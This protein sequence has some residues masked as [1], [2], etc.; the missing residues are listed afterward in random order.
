MLSDENAMR[1]VRGEDI[2]MVFQEPMTSLNPLHTI[3]RQ[4]GEILK[5]HRGMS[6]RDARART[7]ELLAL[8]GIRDAESRLGAYPHQLSGRAA[9]ARDDRHVLSPTSPIFSSPTS[10]PRPSTS[11]YR[12][13]S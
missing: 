13:R 3:E 12:R 1:R 2:T 10:R 11:P 9:S 7:F 6:D 4:V 8:V 5:V